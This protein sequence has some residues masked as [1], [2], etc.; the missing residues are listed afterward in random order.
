MC[1]GWAR[2]ARE[3][4]ASRFWSRYYG[5]QGASAVLTNMG[6]FLLVWEIDLSVLWLWTSFDLAPALVFKDD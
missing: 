6:F 1:G 3:A 2:P 5:S 4:G